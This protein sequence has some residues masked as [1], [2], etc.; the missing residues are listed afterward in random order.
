MAD[1]VAHDDHGSPEAIKAL[2]RK[3]MVVFGALVVLTCLT[4]WIS[5]V[6]VRNHWATGTVVFA[7]LA[8]AITKGTLVALY[9]MHLIDEKKLIYYTLV[10][11]AV[12]FI[13]LMAFP[14]LTEGEQM[15]HRVQREQVMPGT[16]PEGEHAAPEH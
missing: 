12:L 2:I 1:A 13:P 9:F 3:A 15:A 4:V 16:E 5:T 6:G 7:A 11:V 10:L 14:N 8:V